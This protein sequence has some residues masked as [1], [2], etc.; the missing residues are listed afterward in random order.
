M[1]LVGR[2]HESHIVRN[3][4]FINMCVCVCVCVCVKREKEKGVHVGFPNI[5]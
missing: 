5:E 3:W 4:T 1:V 2:I